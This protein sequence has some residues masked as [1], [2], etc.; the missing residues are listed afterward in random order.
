MV[1][2][3]LL[4]V[5][6]LHAAPLFEAYN[7][8]LSGGVP[9]GYIITRFES[10]AKGNLISLAYTRT[11]TMGGDIAESIKAVSDKKFAPISFSYTSKV[12]NDIKLID[13]KAK[14]PKM[15][16]SITENGNTTKKTVALKKGTFLSS[17]L[18]YLMLNNPK[19]LAKGLKYSYEAV[20]EES[21]TVHSGEAF[22]ENNETYKGFSVYKILNVFKDSKFISFVTSNGEILL[23]KS[24]LQGVTVEMVAS[25]EEA[26]QNLPFDPKS[27]AV[28]FGEI[29][30]G[31]TNVLNK[32]SQ[33]TTGTNNAEVNADK[34]AAT[35]NT[36][37]IS[38]AQS[39]DDAL[40]NEDEKPLPAP[41]EGFDSLDDP[42]AK[43]GDVPA[44]QGIHTKS[45]GGGAK[46]TGGKPGK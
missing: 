22:I 26:T 10:D 37:K 5:Q 32:K 2:L 30:K 20:A 43:G 8:I 11:N 46:P 13:G 39:K 45:G 35:S 31:Q 1:W 36:T 42:P 21:G 38:G 25:K 9:T 3:L 33:G 29:P 28:L 6:T 44:G 7:R 19:G 4:V 18:V 23:T 24:P 34:K 16:V 17:V 41:G 40:D 14:G 15:E 12:G 27:I